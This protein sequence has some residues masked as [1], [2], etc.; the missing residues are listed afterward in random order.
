MAALSVYVCL[1]ACVHALALGIRP[2]LD[3]IKGYLTQHWLTTLQL[4]GV[5]PRHGHRSLYIDEYI[6]FSLSL[7]AH[8]LLCRKL[9]VVF[10]VN[11]LPHGF[12]CARPKKLKLGMW[13]IC[14]QS[15]SKLFYFYFLVLAFRLYKSVDYWHRYAESSEL[16]FCRPG[17]DRHHLAE[18]SELRIT[19]TLII[20]CW[21]AFLCGI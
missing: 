13:S 15:N 21:L 8:R 14:E 10:F 9:C 4:T 6:M 12:R 18:P 19:V 3:V 17:A 2:K 20:M 1:C 16:W 7:H 11:P 5:Y